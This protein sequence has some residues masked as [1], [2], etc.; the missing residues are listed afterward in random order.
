MFGR[1]LHIGGV[2]SMH[3][4]SRNIEY[5]LSQMYIAKWRVG[6]VEG[7]VASYLLE[8]TLNSNQA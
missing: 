1:Y 7:G 6:V 2:S 4:F 5:L 3:L 8:Y